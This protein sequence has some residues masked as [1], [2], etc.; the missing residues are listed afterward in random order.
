MDSY[1]VDSNCYFLKKEEATALGFEALIKPLDALTWTMT[2]LMLVIMIIFY[3]AIHYFYYSNDFK[4]SS[5]SHVIY[6]WEVFFSQST[7]TTHKISSD[8]KR[9]ASGS[10]ILVILVISA[11]YSGIL[12]SFFTVKVYPPP[13]DT[14]DEVALATKRLELPLMICCEHLYAIMRE[15]TLASQNYLAVSLTELSVYVYVFIRQEYAIPFEDR[16]PFRDA[17]KAVGRGEYIY[18]YVKNGLEFNRR[19]LLG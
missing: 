5:L 13:P 10:F 3:I 9:I 15:S 8:S 16:L 4:E 17:I 14:I 7:S 11:A 6:A 12:I 1:V 18:L 2:I 19:L